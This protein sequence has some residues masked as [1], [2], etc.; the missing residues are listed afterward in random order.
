MSSSALRAWMTSG[1]PVW[2]AASMCT[3]KPAAC[4]S[5]GDLS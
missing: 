5:R 1:S 4:A 2:R 3:R